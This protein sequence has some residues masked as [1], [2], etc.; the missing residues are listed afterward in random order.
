MTTYIMLFNGFLFGDSILFSIILNSI[1]LITIFLLRE[2][3][4]Q[5][6]QEVDREKR[7]TLNTLKEK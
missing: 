5:C 3:Y 7:E 2:L 4:I 6:K 1:L